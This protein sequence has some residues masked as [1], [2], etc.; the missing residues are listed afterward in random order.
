MARRTRRRPRFMKTQSAISLQNGLSVG[1]FSLASALGDLDYEDREAAVLE[2]G[3]HL[4]HREAAI[5]AAARLAYTTQEY[6]VAPPS[7]A[8]WCPSY[9]R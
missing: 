4:S 2:A 7:S 1:S 9:C 5:C 8:S 6:V 3:V